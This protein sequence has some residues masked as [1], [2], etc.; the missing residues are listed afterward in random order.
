MT[1]RKIPPSKPA[2]ASDTFTWMA[3]ITAQQAVDRLASLEGPDVWG[4]PE[5][6]EARV[7]YYR[8][9]DP[10]GLERACQ[11]F[12]GMRFGAALELPEPEGFRGWRVRAAALWCTLGISTDFETLAE[13]ARINVSPYHVRP[14]EEGHPLFNAAKNRAA[15]DEFVAAVRAFGSILHSIEVAVWPDEEGLALFVVD[16]RRRWDAARRVN[17]QLIGEY[18]DE[19]PFQYPKNDKPPSLI[20]SLKAE[21]IRDEHRARRVRAVANH[22]HLAEDVLAEA[23][24]AAELHF[25]LKHDK[26]E[27]AEM[28]GKSL[29]TI[30][31][32]LKLQKLAPPLRE[33]LEAGQMAPTLAYL[34]ATQPHKQQKSTWNAVKTI[35]RP[36]DRLRAAE[37]HLRHGTLPAAK[38]GQRPIPA[39]RIAEAAERLRTS[40][41]AEAAPFVALL[42]AL[43]GDPEALERLPAQVRAAL[44][45]GTRA[46]KGST[47][48]EFTQEETAAWLEAGAMSASPAG[49]LKRAGLTPVQCAQIATN[50][51]GQPRTL[52]QLFSW[53]ALDLEE[54]Q[55][56]VNTGATRLKEWAGGL[57]QDVWES[58][59]IFDHRVADKAHAG[60]LTPTKL[61][62]RHVTGR[63]LGQHLS[64][65]SMTVPQ[66]QAALRQAPLFSDNG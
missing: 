56:R 13:G 17:A 48:H 20:R 60:G 64:D 44:Q 39:R 15:T 31:N 28:L 62:Q 18:I 37:H 33:A 53:G 41:D 52:A 61:M 6:V 59:D 36:A 2:T 54:V 8:L 12:D 35:A 7:L 58:A 26:Y 49:A 38:G 3:A 63:S 5:A 24:Q 47:W 4:A 16:G 51:V 65:G 1:K 25:V 9:E 11:K 40:E 50:S 46:N 34:L 57:T 66:V 23:R 14:A 42:A 32:L 21:I 22:H 55:R 29:S 43:A 27:V 30:E 45:P 19:L 10:K